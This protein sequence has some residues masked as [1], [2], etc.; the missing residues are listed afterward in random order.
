VDQKQLKARLIIPTF[1]DYKNDKYK[2]ISF[3]AKRARG[4]MV[5][6]AIVNR[7]T[8]PEQ[9]KRFDYEGYAFNAEASSENTWVFR[10]KLT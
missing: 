10:R 2:I 4:L 7:I 3:F 9:L 6:Y 1:E 8:D 5:R